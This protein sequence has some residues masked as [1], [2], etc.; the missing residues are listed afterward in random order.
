MHRWK[1]EAC[2]WCTFF[3]LEKYFFVFMPFFVRGWSGSCWEAGFS[4]VM[5]GAESG[6][7]IL[8]ADLQPESLHPDI[9]RTCV[10][11]E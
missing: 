9:Q 6:S 3:N 1:E 2:I 7:A 11:L 8:G 10:D 5:A 4:S